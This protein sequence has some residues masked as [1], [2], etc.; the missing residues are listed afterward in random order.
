MNHSCLCFRVMIYFRKVVVSS[1][2]LS[3]SAEEY[4][5]VFDWLTAKCSPLSLVGNDIV[6]VIILRSLT[7]NTFRSVYTIEQI[8]T[9]C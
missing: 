6:F 1:L 7:S 8:Q 9:H 3:F 4:F 5:T 2:F